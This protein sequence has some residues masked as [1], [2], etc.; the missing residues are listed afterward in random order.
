MPFYSK[1]IELEI[2]TWSYKDLLMLTISY[3][4]PY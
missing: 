2:V 1:F 4:K 3:L